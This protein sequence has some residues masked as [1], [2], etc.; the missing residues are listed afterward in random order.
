MA[1]SNTTIRY[2]AF[3]LLTTLKQ[4][5]QDADINIAQVVFWVLL[6]ADRLRKAHVGEVDSGAYLVSFNAVT[7][8]VDPITGRNYLVLPA[9]IYDFDN[10]AGIEY[11][12]YQPE[13]DKDSPTFTSV[14]FTRT[15]IPESRRLYMRE[16]EKPSPDNPYF[17]LVAD[18]IYLLG[19]EQ[20]NILT[21]EAGLY[22]SLNPI[23][24]TLSLDDELDLPQE[25]IPQLKQEILNMGA[26]VINMPNEFQIEVNQ[27][28]INIK[29]NQQ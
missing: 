6:H 17:Y 8:L 25:L 21:V 23:D 16:D 20:L 11:I 2:V 26:F 12:T 9:S 4:N 7:V 15:T 24:S 3:D 10:D 29:T 28:K 14:Q 19:V 1:S 27:G 13:I 18:R 5:Y 22:T